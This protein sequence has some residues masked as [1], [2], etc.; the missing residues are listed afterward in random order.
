[1][2]TYDTC[3]WTPNSVWTTSL[4]C[5]FH[6]IEYFVTGV[7]FKCTYTCYIII[8]PEFQCSEATL[9]LH[10]PTSNVLHHALG[11]PRLPWTYLANEQ[12]IGFHCVEPTEPTSSLPCQQANHWVSLLCATDSTW[13]LP[14]QRANHWISL[15]WAYRAYLEPTLLRSESL[16]LIALSLS[17]LPRAYLAKQQ[18]IGFNCFEHTE[19]TSSL[20]GQQANHWISFFF[21]SPKH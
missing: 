20:P 7:R 14:C 4:L 16:D 9:K 1:M 15:L 3:V 8:N 5:A 6:S 11:H 10:L 17:N 19:P 18:I 12:I 2:I 13:S 21:T